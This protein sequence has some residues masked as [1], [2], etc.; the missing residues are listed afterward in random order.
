MYHFTAIFDTNYV[1]RFEL[2]YRSL[3]AQNIEFSMYAMCMDDEA[4]QKITKLALPNVSAFSVKELEETYPELASVKSQR[5]PVDYLFTLSPYYPSFML[6]KFPSIDHICSLD[7]DQYFYDSPEP[8]FQKLQTYS[9]LITPHRFSE[10][11]IEAG[12]EIYGK[13]NVSF[14]VFKND[15]VGNA[16]LALWRSQCLD[17]CD[18]VLSDGKFADQK[19][20]ET[21]GDAFPGKV[22]AIEHMGLGLAPWNVSHATISRQSGKVY[23]NDVPLILYHFQGLRLQR[24]NIV[25]SGL[26]VYDAKINSVVKRYIYKPYIVKMYQLDLQI[27]RMGR[28]NNASNWQ[29]EKGYF[30]LIFGMLISLELFYHFHFYK[31]KLR[32]AI[33]GDP[34][35]A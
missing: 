33:K 5:K 31:A 29:R 27:D 21:W 32:K 6:K 12:I 7:V 9:V 8:I 23:V 24:G 4:I 26:G 25:R 34:Q 18:E 13:Y 17:R 22:Y 2:L 19:Y 11:Q 35:S 30:K 15:E 28:D 3:T 10:E 14:Q 1:N 20:L 16:C